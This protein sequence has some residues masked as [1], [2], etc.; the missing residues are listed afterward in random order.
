[1]LVDLIVKM[2]SKVYGPFITFEME[3]K[4]CMCKFNVHSMACLLQHCCGIKNSKVI[5]NNKISSSTCMMHVL[6][7]NE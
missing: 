7:T 1:M 4:S 5:W 3:R 6:P 2:A